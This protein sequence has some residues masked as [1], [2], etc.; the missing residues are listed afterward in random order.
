MH[1]RSL[2]ASAARIKLDGLGWRTYRFG[3]DTWQQEAWRLY[4]IVGELRFV[5]NWVGSA[6][7]RVRIYVAQVDDNGRVQKEVTNKK[8][9][10]LADTLF[11][12]P[13][14]KAEALRMLGI[15]LTIAGDC[16]IVGRGTDDPE[17]DEWYVV[18]TSELKR[19]GNRISQMNADGSKE[20]LDPN[21]DLVIRVWTPHPRRHLWADSPTRAAMPMLWE[22]ERLTRFVFA[23]IDSRLVSAGIFPL[24][25][26]ASFPDEVDEDGNP[27]SGSEALTQRL[28]R[29]ASASLKGEGTAA[30]VVPIFMETPGDTLGKFQLIEFTS[31]LSKQALELRNEAIRRFALAM[32]IEPS[33]L[34][35]MGE[36]NHW[37]AWQI[38]EGQINVHIVPLMTRICDA[39]TIAYQQPA[40]EAIG[41]EDQ[42][43][44]VFWYDTAPLTVRPE[45]LKD[46]L[47]LYDK[48]LV[49]RETV[50]LAGD[51]KISDIPKDEED[52]LRFTRELMLRDPN[53]FQIPAVRKV[54]GYTDDIL[55]PNTVVTPQQPG[56]PGA[57]PPPPPPPP[58]GIQPTAGGPMPLESV[59]QNNPAGPP[60]APTGLAASATVPTSVHTF[61][62]SNATV[63]R[64]LER[65]GKRLLDRHSRDRWPNVPPYELHTRIRVGDADHAERLLEGAWDHLPV[66]TSAL[67]HTVDTDALQQSLQ[68]Y[69]MTLLVQEQPHDVK[70]LGQ[71]L[72]NQGLL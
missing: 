69:C 3:D 25:K 44:Y 12:G 16:F 41:E 31:E 26:E 21:K 24:P 33:I 7:S 53:L 11:G 63:L 29:T 61:V 50:L 10:G 48:Q 34:S 71:Y 9:A 20:D 19:W 38:M 43:R 28:M 72:T 15:N 40:L 6:C 27:L 64:A 68:H 59:A 32:D 39:L 45:R 55:P 2:V 65:A 17:S 49:S 36:A 14:A 30:G 1:T 66:L 5:S 67:D 22:I 58:T 51:Y 13:S 4:D 60:P 46:T 18:S 47:E 42:E 62:V 54:A 23:Q 57:G 8:I 70:L 35:G 52:L 37:G 56:Q